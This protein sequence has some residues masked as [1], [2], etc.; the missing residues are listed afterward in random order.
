MFP[1]P[2]KNQELPASHVKA[3]SLLDGLYPLHGT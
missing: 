2:P 3:S 1:E